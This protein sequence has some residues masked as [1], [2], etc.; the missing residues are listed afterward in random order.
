MC[1][2]FIRYKNDFALGSVPHM[3]IEN[4]HAVCRQCCSTENGIDRRQQQLL[5]LE[6]LSGGPVRKCFQ[7][8]FNPI[9]ETSQTNLVI[10]MLDFTLLLFTVSRLMLSSRVLY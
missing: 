3:K 2:G 5:L 9:L 7:N 8:S 1:D 6:T 4:M 10:N